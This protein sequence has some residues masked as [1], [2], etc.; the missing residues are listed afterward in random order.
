[1]ATREMEALIIRLESVM[2]PK[3][4]QLVAV[5]GG[6]T[7]TKFS[8]EGD[9]GADPESSFYLKPEY[10]RNNVFTRNKNSFHLFFG[11]KS[12]SE[13]ER[14]E[15]RYSP[16]TDKS[17]L[18]ATLKQVSGIFPPAAN[19]QLG[20]A[21][22]AES[23]LQ[24]LSSSDSRTPVVVGRLSLTAQPQYFFL[25]NGKATVTAYTQLP[26]VFATAE[27][28]RKALAGR[29]KITTPDSYINTLG[30]ALA[31]A[32]DAVW[33][34]P[35]FLHGAVA[36]RM[37]LPG[38]RGA[39]LGDVLGWSD[40]ART[41][42]NA[43]AASQV[44]EPA[45]GPIVM[46]TAL[47]LARSAEKMGTSVFSSGY[48]PRNPG[49]DKRPHHYDMN[50]GFIDQLLNHFLWTGDTAYV[51]TMWPLL[52]RHL[53]W[54]DRN[55]DVDGDNLYDS[56]AA[57]WAS[58]ALQYSGGGVTHSSA[59]N[60]K[61]YQLASSLAPL[62]GEDGEP[63]RQKAAAILKAINTQLWIPEKGIYAEFKDLLGKRLLHSS[64]GVWTV[65]HAID[66]KVPDRFQAWQSLQYINNEIPHIPVRAKGLHDTTLATIA[67]T[68]WQPY[69][70]SLNNVAMSEVMHTALAFWQGGR[71]EDAYKLFKSSLVES[72]YLGASPGNFQ[73]LSFYDAMRGELYRDFADVIGTTARSLVEGLFG[74]FVNA[75]RDTV[76]LQPGFPS[77]WKNASLQTPD[78]TF[79]FTRRGL[80]DRYNFDR[81]AGKPATLHLKVEAP[82][83][84]VASVWVNGRRVDWQFDAMAM[85]TPLLQITAPKAKTFSV[86][87]NWKAKKI[88]KPF[89]QR[90]DTIDALRVGLSGGRFTAL[91]DP[92]QALGNARLYPQQLV[93]TVKNLS[94]QHTVFLQ[95]KQG[96]STYWHPVRLH[97][98][99]EKE[100]FTVQPALIKGS[101]DKVDLSP[102]F[103]DRVTNI[104]KN[105]YLSPRPNV[106]TLQLPTQGIGNWAYPLV[107]PAIIDSGLR[108]R[109]GAA[110][111]FTTGEGIPFSTPSAFDKK[112]ILFTSQWDNYPDSVSVPLRGRA[113]HAHLL[114]AGSTNPMQSRMVNGEVVIAYEDG[115]EE[116][117]SLKNPENW[118]PIEQDFYNDG[119]AFNTG[120]P[121]PLRVYLKTGEDT[122]SFKNYT[123]LKGFTNRAIDGGAGT[124]LH[125]P[126]DPSK[127]L[128]SLTLKAVAND[129]A[130]GL[131]SL[132]LVRPN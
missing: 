71:K 75:L 120:A 37:R 38:W 61:A 126:L 128:K 132:T 56:Y 19:L 80:T 18:P 114:M 25:Q 122:R 106:S 36:W 94:A 44:T 4:V 28:D 67:T 129:V 86:V 97:P 49:G 42:F 98:V 33:E 60:F 93:A 45:T 34:T 103:N 1:M 121:V 84:D 105:K 17:K 58:D 112:N 101:F 79:T 117:L 12:L 50:L 54:E 6:A 57:I 53:K 8:R 88:A 35:S 77:D 118:W 69:T 127:E 26:Q 15:I 116:V 14:Y 52:K 39:Y 124:V 95:V 40:R 70:W 64:P 72:M 107:E 9:I 59:Y 91:Y 3:D 51:R 89:L 90:A 23:P 96:A 62:V 66:S 131:M 82:F 10:C 113:S 22:K 2:V 102:Y 43:Y 68:S 65:Y 30:G 123:S 41:H 47:N 78:L 100:N 13:E 73:Q 46:D 7:G 110:N 92:Q 111:T 27:A 87:I 130:I 32:A 11:A 119:F 99:L 74:V 16:K 63:Y 21:K 104:F 31:V 125:L 109:A 83:S 81:K 76:H 5:Y 48:I 29:I 24:V 20:D 55:F 108:Q 85:G 115:S